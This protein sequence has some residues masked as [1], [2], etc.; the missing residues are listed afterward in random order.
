MPYGKSAKALIQSV[1]EDSKHR[2]DIYGSVETPGDDRERRPAV[3]AAT[4]V[5]LRDGAGGPEALMLRRNSKIVFGGMW[6]FPGG[7]I[8]AEDHAGAEDDEAAARNAAAR[9]AHEEAGLSLALGEFVWFA[10]W[11]PPPNAPVRFATWFFAAPA[12]GEPVRVDDGEIKAHQWLRP[13]DALAR[14]RDGQIDLAP[15]TWMTLRQLRGFASADAALSWCRR[16][17]PRRYETRLAK[18]RDGARVALWAG[19]AGYAT[20]DA[21]QPGPRHRLVMRGSGFVLENDVAP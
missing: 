8:D 18:R 1:A 19:D 15:P 14:H 21:D 12:S 3:P 5:L 7:R 11:T 10:H 4:V 6:V 20:A 17:P 13:A 9:E 2:N 16:T